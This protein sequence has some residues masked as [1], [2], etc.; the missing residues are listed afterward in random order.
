M[1]STGDVPSGHTFLDFNAPLS[2]ERARRLVEGVGP[3]AGGRVV[4]LGCGWAELLLRA[5]AAEPTATGIGVDN[6]AE[7]IARGSANADTRGLAE[8]VA[9]HCADAASW[10][11]ADADALIMVGASHAW[12]GTVAALRAART[13]LRPGG[14]LL[15][16]EGF[17]EREPT[18]AALAA[19]DAEPDELT[20]LAGLV[21]LTLDAGYRPLD[22]CTANTDEWDSFESRWCAGRERWLLEHPE[23]PHAAHVRAEVDQHRDGWLRGYRGILGFAHL[24]LA[25]PA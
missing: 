1:N 22:I 11:A 4:D 12:G 5:L 15:F 14:L 24:T 8:R 13:H 23:A 18:P 21:E 2:D 25:L 20:T 9:L 19:L 7:A 10:P 3:P 17:W 16:G 6:D